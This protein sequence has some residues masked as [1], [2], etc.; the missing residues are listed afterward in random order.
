MA[1]PP[2]AGKFFELRL[3]IL[4]SVLLAFASISTDLYLP[5]MPAMGAALGASQDQMQYTISAY[6]IGFSLGQ[7]FWGPVGDRFGRRWPIG[8]GIVLFILGSAG[9]ALATDVRHLIG[10]R[11]LQALGACASVVLARAIVRD[12]YERDRAAKVLST[13][14]TIMAVAPLIGPSVGGLILRVAPW[15]VIFWALVVIGLATLAGLFTVP[16]SLPRERRNGE[17][18]ARAFSAYPGLVIDRRLMAYAGAL[19]FHYAGVFAYISSSSFAFISYHHLSPQAYGLIFSVGIV[20]LMIANVINA[21]F[22]TRFGGDRMLHIGAG[23]AALF[24][25]SVALVTLT[26]LGGVWLL[27]LSSWLFVAMNGFI[28]ANSVS[29]ALSYFPQRAGAVSALMGAMQYGSGVI[30]SALAGAAADGTPRPMGLVICGA[31]I[32][33]LL[34]AMLIRRTSTGH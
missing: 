20:G 31:T 2:N 19:G 5:A 11:V 6:L 18:L 28:N 30:G 25:L 27:A 3:N 1:L 17:S 8:I 7:L 13:L 29:G 15:Q 33:C 4:L 26:D 12:F 9:C 22:V 14:M 23:L 16:E 21:R 34:C 32:G 24:G 10:F